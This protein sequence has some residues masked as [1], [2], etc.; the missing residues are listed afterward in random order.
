MITNFHN[1]KIPKEK[2]LHKCLS[3]MLDSVIMANKKYY[4]QTLLEECRYVQGKIKTEN[5]ND[6]D[7]VDQIVTLMMKQNL[8]LIVMNMTNNFGESILIIITKT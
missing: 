5:H 4:T 6:D 2:L 8:I 3:I 1:K 7:L